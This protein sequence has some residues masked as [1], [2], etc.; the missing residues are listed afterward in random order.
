MLLTNFGQS[1]VTSMLAVL[2][3]VVLFGVIYFV[4]TLR[5]LKETKIKNND[6]ENRLQ[7]GQRVLFGNSMMGI[8]ENINQDSVDVKVKSGAVIEILKESINEILN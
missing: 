8:V 5:T 6:I 3:M 1:L 7:N 4:K 2:I